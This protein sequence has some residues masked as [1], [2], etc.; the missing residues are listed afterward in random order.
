LDL[1]SLT[2]RDNY[3]KYNLPTLSKSVVNCL[4]T[5]V[6]K[7]KPCEIADTGVRSTGQLMSRSS[8]AHLPLLNPSV[9]FSRY[10]N[11]EYGPIELLRGNNAVNLMLL[12]SR[13][14]LP[15]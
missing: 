7:Q 4:E 1:T 12:D 14:E 3:Y 8:L 13:T 5:L 2:Y 6:S 11:T 15:S 10:Y 9:L